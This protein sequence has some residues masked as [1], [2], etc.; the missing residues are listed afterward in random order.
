MFTAPSLT[1]CDGFTWALR[2]DSGDRV[3]PGPH[4]QDIWR[5]A[6]SFAAPGLAFID[7]GAHVGHYTLRMAEAFARVIAIEPNPAALQT[8]R[9]NLQLNDIGNV[10]VHP[11]AAHESRARLR[12]W[13]PFN[14]TAGPCTR[15]L[16]ADEPA[17]VPA[18]C[19]ISTLHS[20]EDGFGAFLGDVDALPID[21]I[22]CRSKERVRL[23]KIDIEGHEGKALA[24]A[25]ETIRHHQPAILIEMH[26]SMYGERIK[27]EVVEQLSR[28]DYVWCD[29][30]LYQR[31]KM[32]QSDMCPY[33]YAEPVNTGRA[34][35]FLDFA[36]RAN[37][38]AASRWVTA[39]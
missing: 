4:E 29:F 23:I 12:L 32:T 16:T 36:E 3:G 18:D 20:R 2:P 13:D 35:D 5:L 34:Q 30:S 8:L 14:V 10:D 1:K 25:A 31:S 22:A 24:G 26:D 17:T 9:L 21:L 33:I 27:D 37:E 39:L 38:G 6:R 28:H 15:T 19:E 7:V 11:V